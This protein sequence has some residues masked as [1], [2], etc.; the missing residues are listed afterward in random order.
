MVKLLRKDL[1]FNWDESCQKA[2]DKLKE[3]LCSEPILQYPDFTK[4]FILTIDAS[5]KAL[6]AILSQGKV[7]SGLTIVYSSRT[8]NRVECNYSAT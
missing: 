1:K 4:Q 7:G 2:F 5:G 3:I 6:G 8:L